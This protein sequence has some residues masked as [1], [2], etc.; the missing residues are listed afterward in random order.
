M[1]RTNKKECPKCGSD[2]VFDT[3]SR[4]GDVQELE[5]GK[6]ISQPSHPIYGC[7][8]CDGDERFIV[9]QE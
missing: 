5:P 2:E 1:E 4:V 3:G 8:K 9:I 6:P 7:R